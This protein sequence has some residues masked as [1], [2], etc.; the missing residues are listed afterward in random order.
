MQPTL[1]GFILSTKHHVQ[2]SGNH[3]TTGNCIKASGVDAWGHCLYCGSSCTDTGGC[4]SCKSQ[5]NPISVTVYTFY[6]EATSG[7]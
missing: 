6:P 4:K 3:D 1:G 5:V 2:C 7:F